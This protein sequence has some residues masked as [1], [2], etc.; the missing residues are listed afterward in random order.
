M[1]A[2]APSKVERL[3]NPQV[4]LLGTDWK[5]IKENVRRA[6]YERLAHLADRL[7]QV[8]ATAATQQRKG[9]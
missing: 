5:Q 6:L 4:G 9:D 1:F 3:V 8:Q 2:V 7:R